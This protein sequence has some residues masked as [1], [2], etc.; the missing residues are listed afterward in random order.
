[1]ADRPNR[2]SWFQAPDRN[3]IHTSRNGEGL[4]HQGSVTAR[5]MF[6][7]PSP[8][9]LHFPSRR[10][11]RLQ[12]EPHGG[13]Q[14][15]RRPPSQ[16]CS[17]QVSVH[18]VVMATGQYQRGSPLPRVGAERPPAH[19]RTVLQLA[20]PADKQPDVRGL[21][22][23]QMLRP[24]PHHGT[25]DAPGHTGAGHKWVWWSTSSLSMG[26]QMV[27]HGHMLT[28]SHK[29]IIHAALWLITFLLWSLWH[30]LLFAY[31]CISGSSLLFVTVLNLIFSRQR[32]RQNTGVW[33]W[34]SAVWMLNFGT[35]I[36][37]THL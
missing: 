7:S 17:Q 30:E 31:L 29:V 10:P 37:Q 1:M 5:I 34:P 19:I 27:S 2:L 20:G 15:G 21:G 22:S 26:K 33:T 35:W 4:I 13:A 32:D 6:T 36:P 11:G 24:P 8:I 18:R 14:G 25:G 23:V 16:L 12:R 3:H 9:H 28:C